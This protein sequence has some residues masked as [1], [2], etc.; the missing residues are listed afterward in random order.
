MLDKNVVYAQFEKITH[1]KRVISFVPI[2][3]DGSLKP[4]HKYGECPCNP[5]IEINDGTQF[6]THRSTYEPVG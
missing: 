6:I 2:L 5:F 3:P 4:G 1:E